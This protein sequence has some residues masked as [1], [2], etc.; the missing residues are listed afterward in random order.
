MQC[1]RSTPDRLHNGDET[2]RAKQSPFKDY[3]EKAV[4]DESVEKADHE[5]I[6]DEIKGDRNPVENE[7]K[8]PVKD[9]S[10]RTKRK[11]SP[12]K[13]VEETKPEDM[14]GSGNDGGALAFSSKG[15]KA[16]ALAF[17]EKELINQI[18]SLKKGDTP[19]RPRATRIR[20]PRSWISAAR[21]CR[22]PPERPR[23]SWP[24]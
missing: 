20:S 12:K 19:C 18:S 22:T 7:N 3:T 1:F 4:N 21:G 2:K 10:G 5:Q 13:M 8:I 16:G 17:N 9:A 23:S 24:L 11:S 15:L 6:P 14:T